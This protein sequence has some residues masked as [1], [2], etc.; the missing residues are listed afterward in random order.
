MKHDDQK[1]NDNAAQP[2][3][4][5]K[6]R[7]ALRRILVGGGVV[8]AGSMMPDNWTKTAVQTIV[9]PAHAQTS[10]VSTGTFSGVGPIPVT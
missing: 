6:R 8:S 9:L 4:E 10:T 3:A 1:Q 2:V 7:D 5:E